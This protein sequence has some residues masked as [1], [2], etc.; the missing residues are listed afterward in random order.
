MFEAFACNILGLCDVHARDVEVQSRANH[1]RRASDTENELDDVNA[2]RLEFEPQAF[3]EDATESFR[4]RVDALVL[5]AHESGQRTEQHDAASSAILHQTA[6]VVR[7]FEL[8]VDVQ[9]D[10]S[11]KSG[12]I[13]GH[14]L[15]AVAVG[16]GVEDEQADLDVV[17]DSLDLVERVGNQ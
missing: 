1:G 4:G 17:G 10:D 11:G 7:E 14:E 13:T 16:A 2:V 3:G 8:L 5:G 9:L 15:V 12:Q 6:E